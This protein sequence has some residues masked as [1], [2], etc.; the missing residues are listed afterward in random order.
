[1]YQR[2]YPCDNI[3]QV[4][5]G[6]QN[7]NLTG[8]NVFKKQ[9]YQCMLGQLLELKGEIEYLRSTN[10]FGTITWQLGEIWPTGGWGS[11]EYGT[12]VAGQVLGGRWKPLQYLLKATLYP[13]VTATCGND[14]FCMI[15]NDAPGPFA[16]TV[17][18]GIVHFRT[19][20]VTTISSRKV[21]ME[22]S[23]SAQ[24]FCIEDKLTKKATA[25][26]LNCVLWSDIFHK[27]GCINGGA[28]CIMTVTVTSHSGTVISENVVPLTTP[29]KMSLPSAHI[30]FTIERNGEGG[31]DIVLSTN[32]V[33]V[34]ATLTTK[35]AGRFSE[36]AI[37]L[38][39][40]K[41]M[42]KFIPF[43]HMNFNLLTATLRVEHVQQYL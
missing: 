14:S 18:L 11:L 6:P 22:G 32:D 20:K 8:P 34:Y 5:W 38:L 26:A 35:A 41:K 36:N 37:L 28:D 21:Q 33:A 10:A 15:R 31:A 30:T 3:I 16:G 42:I 19:G 4:Y 27:Y 40:G 43:G 12:P 23:S 17:D 24:W 25:N 39:P 13:D 9:L 29:A 7:L 1:M 2:N